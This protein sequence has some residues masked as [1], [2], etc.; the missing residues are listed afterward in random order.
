M[1]A[2]V[3]YALEGDLSNSMFTKNRAQRR[4][5]KGLPIVLNCNP[6]NEP[7]P[8]KLEFDIKI[9]LNISSLLD[10]KGKTLN[11]LKDVPF[12][13]KGDP[14]TEDQLIKSFLLLQEYFNKV[15]ELWNNSEVKQFNLPKIPKEL[16]LEHLIL[17]E[18]AID[19]LKI[20]SNR[21][22]KS[23][24]QCHQGLYAMKSA[25]Q[26]VLK[27]STQSESKKDLITPSTKLSETNVIE[28]I[29]LLN[30][31]FGSYKFD[32]SI[33]IARVAYFIE[34][35]KDSPE[36]DYTLSQLRDKLLSHNFQQ[37]DFADSL[38]D[39]IVE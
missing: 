32:K 34:Q 19:L 16:V 27:D 11:D 7:D 14:V 15:E 3:A 20:R 37:F 1:F 33:L 17:C 25:K 30:K 5:L 8:I 26:K 23:V 10:T 6:G 29:A 21:F 13:K 35:A 9:D 2:L 28:A 12:L 38:F 39:H 36:K 18:N 22:S 4:S 31:L 24:T